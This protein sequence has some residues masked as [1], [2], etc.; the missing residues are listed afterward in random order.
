LHVLRAERSAGGREVQLGLDAPLGCGTVSVRGV[1]CATI[2]AAASI[3]PRRSRRWCRASCRRSR[4]ADGARC[5]RHR[6]DVQPR[7]RSNEPALA[8]FQL[9]W[10]A[11]PVPL[12]R[13][14]PLDAT[15]LRLEPLAGTTFVGHGIPYRLRLDP[16]IRAADGAALDNAT[17]EYLLRVEGQGAGHVFPAPNPVRPGDASVTF[18][19]AGPE[20]RIDLYTLEGER[21][22]SLSLV[23]SAAASSGTCAMPATD[24]RERHLH[25]LC[26]R[27]DGQPP[28]PGGHR[29]LI[30]PAIVH[31][32]L[33]D[34][35]RA[36][37][38][39]ARV[40]PSHRPA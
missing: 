36:L 26:A 22:R 10:N 9:E 14:L 7:L 39:T 30:E 25:L 38:R 34:C 24:G 31:R 16:G 21:V 3:P 4:G 28:G 35:R 23:G 5:R 20:T 40:R 18:A 29:A 15:R 11:S 32:P 17:L 33:H 12:A 37:Q 19:E 1:G 2:A 8:G 27:C 6:R 13:W